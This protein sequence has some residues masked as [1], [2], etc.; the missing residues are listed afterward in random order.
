MHKQ[1]LYWNYKRLSARVIVNILCDST[2][3]EEKAFFTAEY[4]IVAEDEPSNEASNQEVMEISQSDL[5]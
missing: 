2:A 5:W 3:W 1:C 4:D